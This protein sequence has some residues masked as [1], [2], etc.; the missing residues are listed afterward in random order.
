MLVANFFDAIKDGV[1]VPSNSQPVL[2]AL[3]RL[4]SFYTMDT[5]AREFERSGAIQASTL[6]QLPEQILHLMSE[7][8]PHAVRLVDSF[9]L[10]D[11]LLDSALGRS[12]GRVYEDL[13]HRAHVLNPLNKITFNPDYRNNEIVMDSGDGNSILAKL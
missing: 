11:F 10:P 12:D 9:A 8:R 5:E 13:F 2:R 4:F 3:F 6:D 7:V 1:G